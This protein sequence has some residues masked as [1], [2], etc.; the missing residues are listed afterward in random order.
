MTLNVEICGRVTFHKYC[1]KAV[2]KPMLTTKAIPTIITCDII[3]KI[4]APS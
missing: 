4:L 1:K 2:A 3:A